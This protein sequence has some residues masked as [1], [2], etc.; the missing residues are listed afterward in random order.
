VTFG[1]VYARNANPPQRLLDFFEFEWLDDGDDAF[2][3]MTPR[4]R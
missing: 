1:H 2:F 3:G 4:L